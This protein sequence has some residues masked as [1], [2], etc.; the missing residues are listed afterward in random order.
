MATISDLYINNVLMP[1]PAL[2]GVTIGGEPIWSPDTGR[3]ASGKMVGSITARKTTLKIKWPPLT[4][5]QAAT[6]KGAIEAAD[7]FPVQF[8]GADG[9]TRT[10]TMYA[11]PLSFIQYSWADGVQYVI[12]VSVDLIER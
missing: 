7:F 12:D 6:I 10:L 1:A 5:S 11:G 8:T 2:Q 9:T 3:T 4:M